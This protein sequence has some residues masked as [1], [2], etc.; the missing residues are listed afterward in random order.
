M[1]ELT[2]KLTLNR[3]AIGWHSRNH[4]LMRCITKDRCVIS[5]KVRAG[6]RSRDVD[7]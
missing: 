5:G 4:A 6:H 3:S 7:E 1:V 2:F